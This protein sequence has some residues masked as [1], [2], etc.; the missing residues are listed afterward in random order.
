MMKTQNG[1]KPVGRSAPATV[2]GHTGSCYIASLV[3]EEPS[4]QAGR[5]LG[6][7]EPFHGHMLRLGH[8]VHCSHRA[9]QHRGIDEPPSGVSQEAL[10]EILPGKP[11][12]NLR[13]DAVDAD[14][15]RPELPRGSFGHADDG[16]L[17]SA[18]DGHTW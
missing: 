4:N 1:I 12:R 2:Y 7:A 16:M 9:A 18:V 17:G 15:G 6:L 10:S 13:V 14:L 3:R 5:F 11:S 8:L